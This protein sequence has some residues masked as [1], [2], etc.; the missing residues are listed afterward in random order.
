MGLFKSSQLPAQTHAEKVERALGVLTQ[1][2]KDLQELQSEFDYER[3]I[4]QEQLAEISLQGDRLADTLSKI[5][6]LVG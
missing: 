1:T 5:E 6:A 2:K 4:L 3:A